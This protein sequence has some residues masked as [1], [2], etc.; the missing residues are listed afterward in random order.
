MNL[1]YKIPESKKDIT[2]Q[3][4]LAITKL[5]KDAEE[6]E[7]EI[8]EHELVSI[9][10]NIPVELV[11][12]LPL[13]EYTQASEL[14]A[15]ALKE[16]AKMYLTFKHNGVK[17][18]FI[19]DFENITI[20]E[21]STLDD[22]MKN[23]EENAYKIL[24][25]LYRPMVKEILYPRQRSRFTSWF[26]DGESEDK[27]SKGRQGKYLVEAYDSSKHKTD[28]KDVPC[29]IYE[30]SLLFFYSL[31]NELVNATLKYTRVEVEAMKEAQDS[32]ENGDG[33]RRLIHTLY[34]QEKTLTKSTKKL[35]IRYCLD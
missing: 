17:Y 23:A 33:I 1:S 31:G 14:I 11:S 19:P 24:N 15:K 13:K 22:L 12:K 9:C 20:G 6:N 30:S 18:G 16:E 32:G 3:Q 8:N 5:H 10:L 28:F 2:V 34:Q 7:V 27:Y 35:Q 26:K 4:Y 25:V 21:Y 29:E